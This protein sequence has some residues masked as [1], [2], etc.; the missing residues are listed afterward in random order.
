MMVHWKQEGLGSGAAGCGGRSE[1]RQ[2]PAAPG[3]RS[4]VQHLLE[5][6]NIHAASRVT[7]RNLLCAAI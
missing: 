4:S 3:S 6:K 7:G 5:K 2:V 1:G